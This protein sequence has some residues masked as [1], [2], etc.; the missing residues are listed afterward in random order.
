MDQGTLVTEEI[1]E[2]RRLIKE[3]NDAGV[4]VVAAAWVKE[5]E[6]G[7]WYLYLVTPLVP[8]G[9]DARE[10]YGRVNEVIRAM[11]EPLGFDPFQIKVVNP[12]EPFGRVI[13][14]LHGRRGGKVPVRPDPGRLGDRSIEAAYIYPA[15]VFGTGA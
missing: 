5:D 14:E 11:Q 2:G 8:E 13:R 15:A 1:E 9:G 3:L 4:P 12:S 6:G 10:A 7:L